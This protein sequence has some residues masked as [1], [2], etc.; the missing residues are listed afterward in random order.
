MKKE[1]IWFFIVGLLLIFTPFFIFTYSFYRLLSVL[2]GIIILSI[3]L[4]LNTKN[5]PFK[6]VIFPLMIFLFIYVIDY[7]SFIILKKPAIMVLEYTSSEKVSTYNSIFYRIYNCD[8]TLI[9]DKNYH[10]SYACSTDAIETKDISEFLTNNEKDVFN[11]Y[12]NKFIHIKGRISKIIADN[13]VEL[14][15]YDSKVG[16]NGYVNF[17]SHKKIVLKNVKVSQN[18]YYI[19]DEIEVIGLVSKYIVNGEDEEIILNDAIIIDLNIYDDYEVIINNGQRALTNVLDNIYY[20]GLSSI[21]Y[22]YDENNIYDLTYILTDKRESVDNIVKGKEYTLN[23]NEDRIYSLDKID[24][25][26]CKNE[27]TI[28][29]N[30]L[31]SKDNICE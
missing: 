16:I 4:I 9:L 26:R 24:V 27:K 21:Y 7:Y 22:K 11:N 3:G 1:N 10:K 14:D 5:L 18:K 12:K 19:Y 13:C 8:N 2:I 31:Y 30:K 25:I 23:K 15:Y 29:A 6:V 28:F 17:D 20:Y